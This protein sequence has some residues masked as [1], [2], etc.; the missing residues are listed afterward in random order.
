MVW[1]D[2]ATVQIVGRA[3]RLGQTRPV[4]VYHLLAVGTTDVIISSMARE[5]NDML[6]ALLTRTVKQTPGKYYYQIQSKLTFHSS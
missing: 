2:Q 5:K 6:Q 3:H 1:S 4:Y